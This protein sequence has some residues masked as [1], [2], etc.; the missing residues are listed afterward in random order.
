M[1]TRNGPD[2]EVGLNDGCFESKDIC[3][4]NK[5][6]KSIENVRQVYSESAVA[7]NISR[8]LYHQTKTEIFTHVVE[9]GISFFYAQNM[10]ALMVACV[11]CNVNVK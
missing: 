10:S 7:P 4:L 9:L 8:R 3:R 6:V 1:R 5:T 2:N 11:K